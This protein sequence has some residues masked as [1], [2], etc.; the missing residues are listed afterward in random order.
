M[1]KKERGLGRG[2]DAL[3]SNSINIDSDQVAEVELD[4]VI[5]QENQ[6]RK[7]FDEESLGE[8]A[9]SIREHGILQPVLLRPKGDFYEIIA[10]ER[11]WRAAELA[12]LECI[13]AL[14]KELGDVESAEIALIENL[15]RDDLSVI[16][17][18]QA[19]KDIIA[20]NSYTQEVLAERIGKSRTY[21]AN[22]IRLLNL[23]EEIIDMLNSRILA[24]GHARALLSIED[25]KQQVLLA[26]EVANNRLSV[27]E[28]ESKAKSKKNKATISL[29]KAAEIVDIEDR[30]QRQF[31]TK[32]QINSKKKGGRIEIEYY[33]EDDLE[34]IL[35]QIGLKI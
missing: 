19:Y 18:A 27:R 25:P 10:G 17:E 16:E 6:P 4:L 3:L 11:R 12:G 1:T 30:L 13:P 32:V 15:Q 33:N 24:A 28:T 26:R 34:R 22:T 20:R 31:G 2:L 23:P 35:E 8:L 21:V 9:E 5:P 14:I 29:N 7:Y